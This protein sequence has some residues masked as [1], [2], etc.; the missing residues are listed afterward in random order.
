M[1]NGI[2]PEIL[3]NPTYSSWSCAERLETEVGST[4]P[5]MLSW[6]SRIRRRVQF[7]K[8][9]MNFQSSAVVAMS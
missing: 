9:V 6:R 7:V 3:L 4:P 1:P 8:N 5:S 2:F